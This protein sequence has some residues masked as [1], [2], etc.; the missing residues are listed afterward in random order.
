MLSAVRRH[1]AGWRLDCKACGRR[2]R[3][4]DPWNGW[5]AV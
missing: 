2:P 4:T 1:W 3:E 5:V